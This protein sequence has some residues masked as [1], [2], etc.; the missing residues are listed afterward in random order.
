MNFDDWTVY[1]CLLLHTSAKIPQADAGA[2]EILEALSEECSRLDDAG[3]APNRPEQ[4][5]SWQELSGAEKSSVA[6]QVDSAD[7]LHNYG[8]NALTIMRADLSFYPGARV[9][10][11]SS[12][13][14]AV[15]TR[16]FCQHDSEVIPLYRL[17]DVKTFCDTHFRVRLTRGTALDYFRFTH[18]FSE[19]GLRTSLV[20]D[21]VD[22]R[23]YPEYH[24]GKRKAAAFIKPP[25]IRM[26][27][28]GLT[29]NACTFDE[30]ESR[31]CRDSYRLTL[32][33]PLQLLKREESGIELGSPFLGRQLK[34]GRQD[35]PF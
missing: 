21:P 25:E 10:H 23:I 15:G 8:T 18:F 30:R 16:H 29:V 31:L 33:E 3:E 28:A 13:S 17:P 14:P 24:P 9:L 1:S 2:Y 27:E 4:G 32:R 5:R 26:E 19:E 22:L 6:V 20:E 12:R 11:V 34:I 7:S 35:Q